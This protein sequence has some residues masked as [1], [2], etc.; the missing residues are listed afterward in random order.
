M[1][2]GMV[3]LGRMGA[4]MVRRLV[5]NGHQCVVYDRS[6][7]AVG[8]LVKE[9]AVGATSLIDLVKKLPKPRAVWLMLPTALVDRVI[10]DLLPLLEAGDIL[11]DGGNSYYVDD[12]RRAKELAAKAIHYVDVGTYQFDGGVEI[13]ADNETPGDGPYFPVR[14]FRTAS[15]NFVQNG[16]G[17]SSDAK[18][19]R[20]TQGLSASI[21][22]RPRA[23][24]LD[25]AAVKARYGFDPSEHAAGAAAL[26]KQLSH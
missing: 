14:G 25:A 5:R 1:Q 18:A 22:Q 23:A 6:Q 21:A 9:K 11:I 24:G 17:P 10:G 13:Y 16:A 26:T 3:G 8:D 7:Q 2:L 12:I 15:R 19:A 20:G 4:N